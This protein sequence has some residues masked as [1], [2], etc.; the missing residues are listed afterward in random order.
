[1]SPYAACFALPTLGDFI[2]IKQ[3]IFT[4]ANLT[5]V[6]HQRTFLA[7]VLIG[8]GHMFE[9]NLFQHFDLFN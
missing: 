9:Q 6:L 7:E 1:M 3:I 5:S 2:L 8:I 4:V